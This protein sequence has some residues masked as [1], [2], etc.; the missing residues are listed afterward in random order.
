MTCDYCGKGIDYCWEDLDYIR[1]H[2]CNYNICHDCIEKK[3]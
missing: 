1:C 3:T 2:D